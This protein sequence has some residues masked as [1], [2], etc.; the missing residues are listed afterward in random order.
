MISTDPHQVTRIENIHHKVAVRSRSNLNMRWTSNN[1]SL[2]KNYNKCFKGFISV[3]ANR[4]QCQEYQVWRACVRWSVRPGVVVRRS[5][6]ASCLGGGGLARCPVRLRLHVPRPAVRSI[7]DLSSVELVP[8]CGTL[9]GFPILLSILQRFFR[10]TAGTA[11]LCL[12]SSLR[13]PTPGV[14][15]WSVPVRLI[16]LST[17]PTLPSR[18]PAFRCQL[19]VLSGLPASWI[20]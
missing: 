2:M 5:L 16:R 15:L 17:W 13:V 14:R 4:I 1:Y 8:L 19:R 10:S 18:N 3:N 20:P 6:G 12:L 7:L 9:H 11:I